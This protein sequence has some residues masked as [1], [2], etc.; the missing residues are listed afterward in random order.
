MLSAKTQFL[1][2]AAGVSFSFGFRRCF[3]LCYGNAHTDPDLRLLLNKSDAE[4]IIFGD[5][6]I[7]MGLVYQAQQTWT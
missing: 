5:L 2:G 3:S 1:F 7:K 6:E 4:F